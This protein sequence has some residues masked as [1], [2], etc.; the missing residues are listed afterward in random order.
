MT[1]AEYAFAVISPWV[2]SPDDRQPPLCGEVRA[3]VAV[4][5]GG[6]TGLSTALSLREA[7]V[8]VV[9]L[10]QNFAGSGA[11]GRNAGHLTPTIG[12]DLPTLLRLFGRQRAA[13]LVRFA[14]EAVTYTEELIAAHAIDCD[15]V[16]SGNVLAGVHPK[17]EKRLRKA[18]RLAAE[19][20]GDVCFLSADE[21]RAR[22]V[23]PAFRFGVLERRGG[24]LHPGRYVM[25]L[26]AAALRAGVRLFEQTPVRAVDDGAPAIVRCAT[27]SVRADRVVLA[28]NAYTGSLGRLQRRVAPLRV[29]L[30][31]TEPLDD[32]AL[33]ELGWQ[34][35]EGIY[36][37][38]EVLES[39]R[40]S[41]QRTIVGGSKI[42][43]Y[44]WGSALPPAY[45]RAA[46]AVI[47]RA[48][49]ERFPSLAGVRI[50]C[51]WGGWIGFTLDFLPVFG[52]T[53]ARRN[54]HYG[55][56][57]AGHGVAQA[58]LMGALLAAR[59]CDREHP[60]AA[61]LARREH[62]WPREPLRWLA[63]QVING[64]LTALD[65]HTDRQLRR[66]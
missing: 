54:I 39:Y 58:T 25:G 41:A 45:D 59:L 20:G 5:G 6:Y 49:R 55:V 13:A 62:N 46:F 9:V 31:E 40:L 65:R 42:V 2:A 44:A 11:S 32:A 15:Y 27:G 60:C 47:A 17:Q 26:R 36:T 38:H 4:I 43:R 52:V 14:D 1:S 64:A 19:L 35:R 53:G 48:F 21:M 8:D 51:F 12:K 24:T 56:G 61:A 50:A 10:E 16:A 7:G 3:D 29:Q 22:G 30:F 63:A 28:T 33:R 66:S 23:P 37:A 57:Y 34:G 18:A